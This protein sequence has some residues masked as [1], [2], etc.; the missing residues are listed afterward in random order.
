MMI[1]GMIYSDKN[2]CKGKSELDYAQGQIHGIAG[3]PAVLNPGDILYIKMVRHIGDD[4]IGYAGIVKDPL[5]VGSV[6]TGWSKTWPRNY[7]V[8][9]LGSVLKVMS[10]DNFVIEV[11]KILTAAGEPN[12]TR[13]H[14]FVRQKP[15]KIDVG[16]PI[17][18]S[19]RKVFETMI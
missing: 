9:P 2:S 19:M 7:S 3:G 6:P 16:S 10:I 14:I 8:E 18:I 17:G 5:P 1:R 4:L 15:R 11:N 12:T 13:E